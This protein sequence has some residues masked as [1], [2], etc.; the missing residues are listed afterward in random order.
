[1]FTVRDALQMDSLKEATLL[2]GRS[3][4]DQEVGCVDI[5]ETPVLM[6]VRPKEFLITTGYSICGDLSKQLA[7]VQSLADVG[8]AALAIKFGRFVAIFPVRWSNWPIA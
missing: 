8:G 2:A 3:G 7:L 1:M 6:N 4:L 5:S